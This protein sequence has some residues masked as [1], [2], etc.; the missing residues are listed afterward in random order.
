MTNMMIRA[1]SNW[2]H[3]MP[4]LELIFVECP[5]RCCPSD[6]PNCPTGSRGRLGS[7]SVTMTTMMLMM[8]MMVPITQN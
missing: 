1:T 6:E 7:G 3:H 4:G 2:D 5:P 8:L